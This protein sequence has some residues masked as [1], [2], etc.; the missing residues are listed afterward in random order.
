MLL[1]S[2]TSAYGIKY[3][4]LFLTFHAFIQNHATTLTLH[5][6]NVAVKIQNART[7]K[8]ALQTWESPSNS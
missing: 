4:L 5:I 8:V 2:P 1:S 6:V 3:V 7:T